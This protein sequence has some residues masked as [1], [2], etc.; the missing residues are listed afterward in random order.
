MLAAC[1]AQDRAA[2]GVANTSSLYPQC[3]T[4]RNLLI[5]L[6]LLSQADYFV[7]TQKSGLSAII[8]VGDPVVHAL[9]QRLR[10]M[11]ALQIELALVPSAAA[12]SCCACM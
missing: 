5:D 1:C 2:P 11:G 8:E 10:A 6:E 4:T 7:G 12:A 9:P 3:I